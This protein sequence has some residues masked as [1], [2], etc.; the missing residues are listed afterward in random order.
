MYLSEPI[1]FNPN[2]NVLPE[3]VTLNRAWTSEEKTLLDQIE[4]LK[5][6][7]K[8]LVSNNQYGK[9]GEIN[10]KL[11]DLRKKLGESIKTGTIVT[12]KED[13][14]KNLVNQYDYK[15]S[16][17]SSSSEIISGIPNYAVYIGGGVLAYILLTSL[18]GKK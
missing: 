1:A 15:Y 16:T 8:N 9:L 2:A 17:S 14:N 4:L 5:K 12:T 3:L 7:Y 11:T 6:E 18:L 13:Y 10:N